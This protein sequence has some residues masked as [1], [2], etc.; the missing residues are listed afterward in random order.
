MHIF[1]LVKIIACD[2]VCRYLSDLI[3][4]IFKLYQYNIL[5]R[6]HLFETEQLIL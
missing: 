3:F 1:S 5:D 4:I 6:R 2:F